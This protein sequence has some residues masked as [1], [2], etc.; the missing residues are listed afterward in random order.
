MLD[1]TNNNNSN[2][3]PPPPHIPS[4]FGF[5]NEHPIL[6]VPFTAQIG[7]ARFSGNGISVTAAYVEATGPISTTL[8]GS[9]QAVRLRFDFGGFTITLF[10][11]ARVIAN[12]ADGDLMLQFIDPT[13]PHLPQLRY[14]LNTYIAGDV[15]SLGSMMAYTGPT[16]PKEPAAKGGAKADLRRRIKSIAA[17]TLSAGLILVALYSL[18]SRYTTNYELRPVFIM[19]AGNEMRATGG[20]QVLYLNSEAK[21]GEVL[22]SLSATTGDVLNFQSPCDCEVAVTDGMFE[23]ATVLP[24][25]SILT[26]YGQDDKVSVQ[27]QM[28]TEG[29]SRAMSGENVHLIM[30]DGR[31]IPARVI[32]TSATSAAAENGD[33][34]LP[35]RMEPIPGAL[36]AND[37]GKSARVRL[38]KAIFAKPFDNGNN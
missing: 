25:D 19:R 16:Q 15:V 22:Y 9:R 1:R 37:I 36:T 26:L 32:L 4:E 2:G 35:V 14:I 5:D 21:Q 29:L 3:T 30:D 23:G 24:G 17:A 20:G 28:S 7:D 31:A 18:Y 34:F 12:G 11:E 27:T 10:P 33:I 13:G 8:F 6:P 38:S